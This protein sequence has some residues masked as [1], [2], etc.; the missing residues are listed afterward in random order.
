MRFLVDRGLEPGD[1]PVK[2]CIA[3]NSIVDFRK[4]PVAE[5]DWHGESVGFF[6]F[7]PAVAAELAMRARAYVDGGRRKDE[8]EEAIRDMIL[9]DTTRFGWVDVTDLPWTEIDFPEDAA[10]ARVE[11]LPEL[12]A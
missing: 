7:S 8:Y 2:L 1:E 5:H 6:K 9:A 11:I 4:K 10:R 3:G 12:V